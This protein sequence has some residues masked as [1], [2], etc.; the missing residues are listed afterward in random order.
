[1]R[2]VFDW[3]QKGPQTWTITVET[4]EDTLLLSMGGAAMA[5]DGVPVASGTVSEY[6]AIYERFAEL[7]KA[8]ERDVDLTPLRHVA[9]AFM[10]GE[11]NEVAPFEE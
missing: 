2:A 6:A 8:G 9:D 3:R 7:I 11:R 4:N 1:M 5:V 10:L